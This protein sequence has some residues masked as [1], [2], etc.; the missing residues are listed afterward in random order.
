VVQKHF[1]EKVA[2]EL[3]VEVGEIF[4]KSTGDLMRRDPRF[5][6]PNNPEFW[7]AFIEHNMYG[8]WMIGESSD[9]AKIEPGKM[10]MRVYSCRQ[11]IPWRDGFNLGG[12][13]LKPDPKKCHEYCDAWWEGQNTNASGGRIRTKRLKS[14]E[15][16]GRCEWDISLE[17][18]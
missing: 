11:F 6:D 3:A 16:D 5:S 2:N 17:K 18:K 7:D 9:I 4:G 1:G 13:D 15:V 14:M 8:S 12:A 10:K